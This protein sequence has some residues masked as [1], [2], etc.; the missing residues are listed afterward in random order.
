[1]NKFLINDFEGPLDLLL[2]LVKHSKMEI[3]D[4][5]I[6]EI[7]EQYLNYI[8]EM[9][10]LNLDI[11]S[12]YLVMACELVEMKSKYLLPKKEENNDEDSINIEDELKKRLL[13]YKKYKENTN[14]FRE[15]EVKRKNFYTKNPEILNEITDK[16]VVNY[17]EVSIFD[18]MDALKKLMNAQE[19]SRPMN[20][21][22][23]K[24]ELS[25][26]ERI[27]KIRNVLKEKKRVSFNSLF[28]E[29][30]KSYIVVTFLS[31]LQMCKDNEI[32]LRQKD[33]FGEILIERVE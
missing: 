30:S 2:H 22:I 21:K 28:E 5:K 6:T 13:E 9:T 23:T 18:L 19:L 20:T 15:L 29:F 26:K 31:V 7:T 17:G 4:I 25:I 33:N 32:V 8:N 12:E 27:D 1:M 11:A 10:E 3:A 24:K 16:K 14:K